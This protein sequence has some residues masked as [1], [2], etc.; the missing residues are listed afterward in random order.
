MN[1]SEEHKKHRDENWSAADWDYKTS[2]QNWR[3]YGSWFSWGSPVGLGLFFIEIGVML[4][5]LHLAN[6]IH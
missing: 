2:V 1:I 3:R 5:L 6:I 4:Y